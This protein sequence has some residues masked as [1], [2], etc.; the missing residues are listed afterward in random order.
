MMPSNDITADEYRILKSAEIAGVE[1]H[2]H[3]P[4]TDPDTS[5]S[6]LTYSQ[7]DARV[8]EA[9]NKFIEKYGSIPTVWGK[10]K[11]IYHYST[12]RYLKNKGFRVILGDNAETP[13][14]NEV[15]RCASKRTL[16]QEKEPTYAALNALKDTY[17]G[18]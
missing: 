15:T 13:S 11:G 1:Y 4:Y 8:T 18:I 3:A 7:L 16:I 2:L 12:C 17:G 6:Y 14:L 10:H 5:I 9:I